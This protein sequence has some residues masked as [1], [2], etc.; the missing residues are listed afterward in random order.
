MKSLLK[1]QKKGLQ[2]FRE[3]KL[4]LSHEVFREPHLTTHN[5]TKHYKRGKLNREK[6]R[7]KQC[8]IK[9]K[10]WTETQKAAKQICILI[11]YLND[12]RYNQTYT[13]HMIISSI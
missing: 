5:L 3:K 13:F 2:N 10:A 4:F 11:A 8:G 1:G 9:K 7:R 6:E 12:L